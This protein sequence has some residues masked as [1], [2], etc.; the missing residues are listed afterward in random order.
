MPDGAPAPARPMPDAAA[1]PDLPP[2]APLA[3]TVLGGNG[4]CTA[5]RRASSGHVVG[6]DGAARLLVDAGGGSF[7][8]LGPAQPGG[9]T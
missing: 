1:A 3:I 8:R 5:R 7:E 2:D 4:P 6:L 9:W